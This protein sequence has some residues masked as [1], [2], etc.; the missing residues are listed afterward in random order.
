VIEDS[1]TGL[2]AARAAGMSVWWFTGGSHFRAAGPVPEAPP[3]AQP[4][5]RFDDFAD[6][7]HTHPALRRAR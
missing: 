5:R 4:Q 2:R 6:F 7:F 1:L 3:E